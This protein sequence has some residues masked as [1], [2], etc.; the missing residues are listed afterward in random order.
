MKLFP[1]CCRSVTKSYPTLCYPMNCS[2]PGSPVHHYPRICSNSSLL[3]QWCH[4]TISSSVIHFV[5]CTQSFPESRS[6]PVSHS[7]RQVDSRYA[8][9]ICWMDEQ[10]VDYQ[11]SCLFIVFFNSV[12]NIAWIFIAS[13]LKFLCGKPKILVTSILMNLF[14][15]KVRI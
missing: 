9:S 12:V 8:I 14:F 13:H 6:F 1:H 11:Y 4:P 10:M 5:S 15:G 7:S 3:S 2:T